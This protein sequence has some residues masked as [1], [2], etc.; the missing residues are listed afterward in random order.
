M[1]A[2]AWVLAPGH[3]RRSAREGLPALALLLAVLRD[4]GGILALAYR[5]RT[6]SRP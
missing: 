1:S 5:L 3:A 6:A 4:L 2:H